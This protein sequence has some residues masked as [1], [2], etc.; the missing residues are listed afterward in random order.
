MLA[1]A[2]VENRQWLIHL[3]PSQ[4][5]RWFVD[6]PV[7]PAL[8]SRFGDPCA[9]Q[10]VANDFDVARLA[11]MRGRHDRHMLGAQ[12]EATGDP[13]PEA[14]DG[15]KRLGTGTEI[16]EVVWIAEPCAD[17]AIRPDDGQVPEVNGLLNTSPL[18]THQWSGRVGHSPEYKEGGGPS[19][20]P[21][22]N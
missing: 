13:G 22:V 12:V 17:L 21:T 1:G 5:R 9:R 11:V 3:P 14:A 20:G 2:V 19:F 16:G 4:R 15:L 6:R 7:G 18:D 10:Q 8:E